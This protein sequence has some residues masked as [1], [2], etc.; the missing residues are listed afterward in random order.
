M[1]NKIKELT[2][3]VVFDADSRGDICYHQFC[4]LRVVII[5]YTTSI[6]LSSASEREMAVNSLFTAAPKGEAMV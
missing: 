2:L 4:G 6:L 3:G 5:E 1:S